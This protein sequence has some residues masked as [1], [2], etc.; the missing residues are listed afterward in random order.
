MLADVARKRKDKGLKLNH[1]EPLRCSA[2]MSS[3]APVKAKP[4]KR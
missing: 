1:P 3:T 2:P 4:S